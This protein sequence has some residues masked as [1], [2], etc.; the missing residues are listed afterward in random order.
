METLDDQISE[1]R[2]K[3]AAAQAKG[4]SKLA[5]KLYQQ[6]QALLDKKDNSP[7]VGSRGRAA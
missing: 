2:D 5:N 4:E 6:E 7:I 3:Q 1:L